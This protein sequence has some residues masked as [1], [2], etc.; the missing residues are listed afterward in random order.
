VI[1]L[2]VSE[3]AALSILEQAD[4]YREVA[5]AS[6]AAQWEAAID[7]AIHS[8]LQLPE[9]GAPCRFLHSELARLRWIPISG[10]PRHMIFYRYDE[11]E[12]SVLVVQIM[13]GARDIDAILNE[14]S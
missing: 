5:E 13:H 6:L 14:E 12:S 11:A 10:F 1:R 8:L 9:R 2:R 7:G 4:Y 3:A